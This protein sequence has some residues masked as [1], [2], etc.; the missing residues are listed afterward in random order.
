MSLYS[1]LYPWQKKIIDRF[2][3]RKSFGLFLDMGLG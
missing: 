3:N 2:S 1:K